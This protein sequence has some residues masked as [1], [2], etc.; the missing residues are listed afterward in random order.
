MDDARLGQKNIHQENP[1]CVIWM[2]PVNQ[3]SYVMYD[4][5]L[6][7][8]VDDMKNQTSK[9]TI[10]VACQGSFARQTGE[11]AAPGIE[12]VMGMTCFAIVRTIRLESPRLHIYTV[13]L[14][15]AATAGEIAECLRSAMQNS[16]NRDEIA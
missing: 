6:L 5:E 14:P 4:L 16:G 15:P 3:H 9:T 2:A 11:L 8:M 1:N 13:D 10:M 12:G 7:K